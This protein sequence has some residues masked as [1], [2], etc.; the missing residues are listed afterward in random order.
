MI[1]GLYEPELYEPDYGEC[2]VC[3]D[4]IDYCQ[5]HPSAPCVKCGQPTAGGGVCLDCALWSAPNVP[6]D[7]L[8]GQESLL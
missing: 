3:G 4:P 6:T 5:G 7:P 1:V 8:D 2:P